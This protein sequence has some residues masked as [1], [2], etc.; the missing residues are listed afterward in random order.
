MRQKT[1]MRG[2]YAIYKIK[3]ADIGQ[4]KRRKKNLFVFSQTLLCLKPFE[5]V[6]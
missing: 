3:N 4:K 5:D 6:Q 1:G 2:E